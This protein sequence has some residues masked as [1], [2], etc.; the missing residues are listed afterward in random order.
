M[1]LRYTNLSSF[2]GFK[3][4]QNKQFTCFSV[5]TSQIENSKTNTTYDYPKSHS[6][7]PNPTHVLKLWI[8]VTQRNV[9]TLRSQ[10]NILMEQQ[11]LRNDNE[12]YP[13]TR[14]ALLLILHDWEGNSVALEL[15][16]TRR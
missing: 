2:V 3:I 6:H 10:K 11:C 5:L 9:W 1:R 15:K 8:V 7:S 14:K 4:V 12:K 13:R 16:K